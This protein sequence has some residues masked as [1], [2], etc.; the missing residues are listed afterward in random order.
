V[1]RLRSRIPP[2]Y[3]LAFS[4]HTHSVQCRLGSAASLLLVVAL[5]TAGCSST[6]STIANRQVASGQQSSR[7][8]LPADQANHPKVANEWWYTV[9]HLKSG[10]RR[11]GYEVTIFRLAHFESAG[12]QLAPTT[13]FRVDV[14]I[15][16]EAS[17]RFYQRVRYYFPQSANVSSK[18]LHAR[19]GSASLIATSP[20]HMRLHASFPSGA[21]DLNLDSRR[22]A[23]DVGGSGYLPMANGFTYY[24]S[25]TDVATTGT[26]RLGSRT[27]HVTGVSW[28]DHQWGNWSWSKIQGWTWMALQLRNGTQLS[29]FDFR[30]TASRVRGASLLLRN[31]RLRTIRNVQVTSTG[32]WHSRATGATYPSGWLVRIPQVA[33]SLRIEPSVSDQELIDPVQRTASYWEGSGSVRGQFQGKPITG[34]SYTELTGYA[35][36]RL[37][38]P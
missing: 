16:D 5:L 18:T 14:A 6:Q 4:D 11:F 13:V 28:Q 38:G 3:A 23:M 21:I 17:K 36:R 35:A 24:Y 27:Y 8:H 1:S 12:S 19:V 32:T 37:A 2:S 9:G 22:P 31:G 30:S 25:L 33:A 20:A 7:I 29:I 10:S 15:T 34:S 26:I